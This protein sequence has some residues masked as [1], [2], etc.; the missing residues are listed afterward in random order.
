MY[1][2]E[3]LNWK[4]GAV[5]GRTS[6]SFPHLGHTFSGSAE[7]LWIFSKRWPHVVQRYGYRG[8]AF[9]FSR[10]YDDLTSILP[11]GWN[12]LHPARSSTTYLCAVTG[13]DA[14]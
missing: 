8:K 1:H 9:L 2:P 5:S 12:S 14:S 11:A 6:V 7:K 4:R 13:T 10:D 3:P